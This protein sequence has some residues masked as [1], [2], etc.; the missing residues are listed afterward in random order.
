MLLLTMTKKAIIKKTYNLTISILILSIFFW[1]YWFS[2]TENTNINNLIKG[3]D[4]VDTIK[5]TD[6]EN[7]REMIKY[8]CN[9]MPNIVSEDRSFKAEESMFIYYVCNENPEIV[10]GLFKFEWFWNNKE[11]SYIKFKEYG[12][13]N[14]INQLTKWLP[15]FYQKTENFIQKLFDK[16]IWSY[17]SI[18]QAN[19]YWY[20]DD[21]NKSEFTQHFSKQYFTYWWKDDYIDIC[22]TNK[23]Y[24]YPNTCKKL[25][26][27]FYAARNLITSN[28]DNILNDENIFKNKDKNK[29]K[30]EDIIVNWLYWGSMDKFINLVYNELMYYSLFIEY[31]SYLLQSKSEFKNW[32]VKN[33]S[34]KIVNNKNRVSKM[35]NNL[36][37]SKKAIQTSIQILKEAQYTFPIHIWFLMYSEDVHKFIWNMNKTLTPIYTLQDIFKNVQDPEN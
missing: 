6:K 10:K 18:Y 4:S 22:A 19:I 29:D 24:S 26:E 20:I 9:S 16:I 33:F 37:A 23:K 5:K 3:I 27:Y 12:D 28:S 2:Q 15:D 1:S 17:V 34:D 7:F 14:Q 13:G 8:F 35:Y 11:K 21:P 31:Y 25:K 36:D 32:D 30:K